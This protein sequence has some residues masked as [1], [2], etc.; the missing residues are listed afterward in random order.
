[1]LAWRVQVLRRYRLRFLLQ[2]TDLRGPNVL[3]GRSDNCQITLDDP[4][5]SRK[6]AR[7]ELAPDHARLVDLDSRN[8]VRLN[9]EPINESATLRDGDRVGI[10]AQEL[11]FIVA[12]EAHG[13][14]R[15]TGRLRLCVAC[16][17]PYS[18]ASP[19]CPR[20]GAVPTQEMSVE[21]TPTHST[22]TLHLLTEVIE[23]A[24]NNG[25]VVHAERMLSK[26][27]AD[28]EASI[29]AGG[30][31]DVERLERLLLCAVR[32][33]YLTGRARWLTW[34]T[35]IYEQVGL[36]P[37]QDM[38]RLTRPDAVPDVP[39]IKSVAKTI[40]EWG[41]RISARR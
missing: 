14:R 25:R 9:G 38:V 37:G 33:G 17:I 18:K 32:L 27:A 15:P 3:I 41:H 29:K 28:L 36:L 4:M 1:M 13:E 23:P 12:D 31:I 16:D 21:Q 2:E 24:L 34:A 6:H 10:G 8:G 40:Y 22:W 26:G 11:V 5:V 30:S 7:L 19:N 35:Q 20:C 39:E